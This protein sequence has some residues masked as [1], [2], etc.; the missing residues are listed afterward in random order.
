MIQTGH[1]ANLPRTSLADSAPAPDPFRPAWWCRNAHLQTLWPYLLRR[2]P[3]LALTRERL[4]LP[5]GDFLDLDWAARDGAGPIV[6]VLHG[7]EG[8]SESKYA[9][10]LVKAAVARGWRAAILNF[11]GCS[12][13]PNRL[14][15]SYHSGE[16]GDLSY[17]VALLEARHPRAPIAVVGYSLGGNA[18]LKWLGE[19]R[20]KTPVA[21][22]AAVSVPFLLAQ[23]AWRMERGFSRIYQWSLVHRLKRSIEAKRRRMALPL[24]DTDLSGVH[25]FREFDDRVTAPL[26]GFAGVNEY[27]ARSSSRQYLRHVAVPTLIVHARDDP[28]MTE[29]AIP[30]AGE[31]SPAIEFAL[32]ECGGHVGFVSGAWPWRAHYWLERRIPEFLSRHLDKRDAARI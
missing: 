16:T 13:E 24:V 22:A 6:L 31:L 4:E 32:Q 9:L 11:R 25:S 17:V 7:L 2:R 5:D 30:T 21:A 26:H 10:G 23:C 1:V 12:G 29:T 19:R 8:S 18:L 14:P 27:Y 15:R 3:R 20:D 28:F